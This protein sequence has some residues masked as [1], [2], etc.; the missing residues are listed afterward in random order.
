MIREMIVKDAALLA[1]LCRLTGTLNDAEAWGHPA[2]S[3]ILTHWWWQKS[4]TSYDGF[5]YR[6]ELTIEDYKPTLVLVNL[7][8]ETITPYTRA[9]W[10]NIL[11]SVEIPKLE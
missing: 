9:C 6:V 7:K 10:F 2:G 8:T 11:G 4:W 1:D 3:L 5:E